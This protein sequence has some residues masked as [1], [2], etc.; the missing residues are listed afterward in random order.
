MSSRLRPLSERIVARLPGPYALWV[1]VWALVPWLNAG[2]NLLLEDEARSAVW[3]QSR[4]LVILNYCALTVAIVITLWGTSRIARRLETLRAAGSTG[5]DDASRQP[6]R[7]MNS[8]RGPLLACA[9]T[10]IAFGISGAVANGWASGILRGATWFVL[11]IP[12]WSFLWT[13]G[14]L[15]LGLDRL[16]RQHLPPDAAR[17][18]PTLGLRP[19]GGAAFMG[20]WML[21]A[22]LVPL[23]LTGLP[24]VVGALIGI[25]VLLAALGMFTFSLRRL[26]R[27]MVDAKAAE[28]AVARELYAQ[29]YEPVRAAP[30]LETLERQRALLGAADALEKRAHAIHEWPIDEG[31]L[32]RVLTI[33]TSVI[34]MVIAR[35]LLDPLGL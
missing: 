34:A 24:D 21:L 9:V 30:S 15:Q 3:E 13:Y 12:I 29:A 17:V 35:M 8:V 11:G 1:F 33:T 27:Q 18:D 14:S 26:H 25:G 22:W 19:L 28:L 16:G 7:E 31:T 4:L 20:L 5:I 32:A 6:F 2:A 10:A 23:V